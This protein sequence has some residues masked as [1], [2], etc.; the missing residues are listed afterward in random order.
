ML[1]YKYHKGNG[2]DIEFKLE[3]ILHPQ[4]LSIA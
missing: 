2:S 3:A 1:G 4:A